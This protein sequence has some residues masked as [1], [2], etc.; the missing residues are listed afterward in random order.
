MKDVPTAAAPPDEEA[1]RPISAPVAAPVAATVAAPVAAPVPAPVPAPLPAMIPA[2]I[3]AQALPVLAPDIPLDFMHDFQPDF[4]PDDGQVPG[5]RAADGM[6]R[7]RLAMD[8]LGLG[9]FETDLLRDTVKATPNTFA[10][11]GLP[12]P[13]ADSAEAPRHIFWDCYHP[14]DQI[15]ARVR[16]QSDLRRERGRDTYRERVRI[17]HGQ[18]HEI[19]WMEVI[20]HI[21]GEPGLRSHIVGMFRDVTALVAAEEQQRLLAIEVNHRANNVLAVAQALVAMTQGEDVAGFRRALQTRILALAR[22]HDLLARSAWQTDLRSVVVHETA[23]FDD[24]VSVSAAPVL[25]LRPSVVQAFAMLI[26][27]LAINAAKHGALSEP[28]GKV[29]VTI[30]QDGPEIV[31]TWHEQGGPP[32][33]APPGR[34]GTGTVLMQRLARSMQARL[35]PIWN[36]DGLL[37]ELRLPVMHCEDQ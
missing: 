33:A 36:Q 30:A 18:S 22:T 10:M 8:N 32:I 19:R 34:A 6:A 7:V 14:D 13:A 26:H 17:I 20:G 4:G 2:T 5:D 1:P 27:E 28:G 24:R 15:W 29:A 12:P 23:A 35:T 37:A 16:Y 11:F 25:T 9:F 21:F 31:L 3:P